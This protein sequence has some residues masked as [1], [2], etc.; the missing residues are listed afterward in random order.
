[1]ELR[2][3]FLQALFSFCPWSSHGKTMKFPIP[4]FLKVPMNAYGINPHQKAGAI[5]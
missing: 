5:S 2:E 3:F 1:M 4:V